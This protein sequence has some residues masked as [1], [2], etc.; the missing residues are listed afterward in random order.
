LIEPRRA[1]LPLFTARVYVARGF[2]LVFARHKGE[3]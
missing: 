2:L 3:Q 1:A